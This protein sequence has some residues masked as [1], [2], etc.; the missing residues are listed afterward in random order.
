MGRLELSPP[1]LIT[2]CIAGFPHGL[3]ICH[4]ALILAALLAVQ[5]SGQISVH[6]LVRGT[7]S[8]QDRPFAPWRALKGLPSPTSRLSLARQS[9]DN[10]PPVT[11]SPPCR[12]TSK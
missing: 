11:R 10:S 4:P 12:T 3:G 8:A 7:E 1:V 2:Q 9:P 6:A 5:A